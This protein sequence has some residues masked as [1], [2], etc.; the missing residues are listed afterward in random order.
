MLRWKQKYKVIDYVLI[1]VGT[2][3]LAIA[4]NVYF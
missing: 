1:I 3:L 4:L 2:T